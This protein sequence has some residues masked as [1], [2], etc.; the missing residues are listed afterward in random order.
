M[1]I[2]MPVRRL[3]RE[4]LP[5]LLWTN[6]LLFSLLFI[7]LVGL[8]AAPLAENACA[9]ETQ[10]V[11]EA[12]P[13][14]AVT[15][16][17]GQQR[18]AMYRCSQSKLGCD[19]LWLTHHRR[20]AVGS[21]ADAQRRGVKIVAPDAERQ[22][23]AHPD[24]FWKNFAKARF[25]DYSCFT[26]K[27]IDQ[28][29]TV[30]HWV[31]DG[32][33]IQWQELK[34]DV[35]STPGYPPGAVSYAATIDGQ[36]TVFTGDL[37]YGDGQLLDLYSYQD[38]I[39]EANIRGYH[40]YAGRLASLVTSLRKVAALKP[41]RLVPARGP[42]I[43]KPAEAINRL[44]ERVQALY[45]NYL[46]TNALHW[47]FKEERMRQCGERILGSAASV[48]L[49][50]YSLHEKAPDW[51]FE[52][53]TSRVLISEAGAGFLIDCGYDRVIEAVQKLIDSG[54][55][56]RVEGIFVTHYHD[57]HTD[58]VQ[59]AAERFQCPVYATEEYVDILKN[60]QA[61]HMPAMTDIPIKNV[62]SLTSGHV[63]KWHEFELTFHYFPGQAYYHGAL[64]VR[65]EQDR[66]VF[67]IGDALAPS[68]I[69]DYCLQNRNLV[70]AQSGY[71]LCFQKL[72]A[73][74]EPIWLINEH[75]PFVFQFTEAER[76]Y[77]QTRYQQRTSILKELFPWDAP[78]YG[79]DEQWAVFYPY[80]VT[81][82]PGREVELQVNVTNHSPIRRE[83]TILVKVPEG[84]R[85]LQQPTTIS[86]E[87]GMQG[88]AS[89]RVDVGSTRGQRII[90]A[91]VSSAGMQF[92]DWIEAL[93]T[94]E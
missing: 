12:G 14:N 65:R 44:I 34:L 90:T 78:N 73:I 49:M 62:T 29:L 15:L 9:V 37:I 92:Q 32:D 81:S 51:I 6:H 80:G 45:K 67:F 5:A 1:T 7:L 54:L 63:M 13:V 22:W 71:N 23:L 93:V 58:R 30:D 47:Y 89:V 83:F 57:D 33:S 77:L 20:E 46:S 31:K 36:K 11:I 24:E 3:F 19:Q 86:L 39:P 43:D 8:L 84:M 52:N 4:R 18:L 61:Y 16:V 72:Q 21:A 60:P 85:I 82:P 40:G 38:A 75:I 66:P 41:D 59:A 70:D 25:H 35:I 94:V 91:D 55:I 56:K 64:L 2:E 26:T 17:S 48:E 27:I 88:K 79:I 28:P 50:P 76:N 42:V 68:G 53:A 69:D 87:P 74:K 10:L